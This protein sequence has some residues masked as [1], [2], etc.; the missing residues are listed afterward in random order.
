MNLTGLTIIIF[1]LFMSPSV[2]AQSSLQLKVEH[3]P[4]LLDMNSP[5]QG[6]V[7]ELAEQAFAT[8]RIETEIIYTS[9]EDILRSVDDLRCATFSYERDKDNSKD[10]YYSRAI[11]LRP[12]IYLKHI[13]SDIELH[14]RSDL[15]KY[16]L[17]F[18]QKEPLYDI[19]SMEELLDH[20]LD[21][22]SVPLYSAVHYL[23]NNFTKSDAK[24]LEFLFSPSI[25]SENIY[26]ACHKSHPSCF[27]LIRKFNKGLETIEQNGHRQRIVKKYLSWQ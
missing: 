4:P 16:S 11:V 13:D 26:L 15:R 9:K 22:F 6:L 19:T 21:L 18:T 20:K 17:K 25:R 1:T 3:Y 12:Y 7:Y 10:W 23:K 24:N 27:N 14:D 5:K 8:Q 2:W